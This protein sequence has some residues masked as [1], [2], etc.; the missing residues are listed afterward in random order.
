MVMGAR[1]G[2]VSEASP[3]DIT[4]YLNL[5]NGLENDNP[6]ANSVT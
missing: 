1:C 3:S 4:A 6:D 5:M 2:Q